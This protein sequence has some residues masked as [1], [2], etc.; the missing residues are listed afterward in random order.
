MLVLECYFVCPVDYY[1][2][3]IYNLV[4]HIV[5]AQEILGVVKESDLA[6]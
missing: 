4:W 3:S 6:L 1:I 2:S 5:C